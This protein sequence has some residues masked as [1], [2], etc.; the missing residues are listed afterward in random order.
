[1]AAA[2]RTT[3]S[4][5]TCVSLGVKHASVEARIDEFIARY[6]P[7]VGAGLRAARA[8]LR[9]LFPRGHE[10]VFDNYNALVFGFSPTERTSGAF[11]SVAGYPRWVTL[12]FLR[13][14][15]LDDPHALLQ[16]SGTQVRGIRLRST[17]QLSEPAVQALIAQAIEPHRAELLRAAP[18]HTSIKS[19]AA[20]QRPRRPAGAG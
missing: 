13:G 19:V 3:G 15:E 14:V 10:L 11:I 20:R 17:Q 12:F 4:E 1:M 18:L 9:A 5:P 6:T 8:H 7:E 16:G 2:S